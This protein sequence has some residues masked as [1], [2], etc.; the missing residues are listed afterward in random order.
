MLRRM[1]IDQLRLNEPSEAFKSSLDLARTI[2]G[3]LNLDLPGMHMFPFRHTAYVPLPSHFSIVTSFTSPVSFILT[4][5]VGHVWVHRVLITPTRMHI[6]AP[7]LELTNR[8][9]RDPR[10]STDQFLRVTFV[11][12]NLRPTMSEERSPSVLAR[13]RLFL[14]KGIER[15]GDAT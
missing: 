7:E 8:V 4:Y 14:E 2:D 6:P 10:F 9:L 3:S 12:E 5:D 1:V 15:E 13:I 11:D